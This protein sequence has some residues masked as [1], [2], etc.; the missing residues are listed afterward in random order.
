[1]STWTVANILDVEKG[2]GQVTK[3]DQLKYQEIPI[4]SKQ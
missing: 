2:Y 4:Q 1:M 3:C